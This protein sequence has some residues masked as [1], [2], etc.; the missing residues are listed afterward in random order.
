[1][2]KCVPFNLL[3]PSKMCPDLC[4]CILFSLPAGGTPAETPQAELVDNDG[5]FLVDND[6]VQLVDNS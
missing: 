4:E 1:M 5:V 6:G 3:P 2:G